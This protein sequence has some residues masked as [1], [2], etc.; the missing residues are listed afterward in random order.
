[1]TNEQGYE[2]F[3]APVKVGDI[4]YQVQI[5]DI[6]CCFC[7]YAKN[8]DNSICDNKE[9]K[10]MYRITEYEVTDLYK[11]LSFD[12][13]KLSLRY[14][15]FKTKEEALADIKRIKSQKTDNWYDIALSSCCCFV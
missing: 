10:Q 5:K 7:E 1:M 14:N 6:P 12:G 3:I 4:L 15:L 9:C 8:A 13:E 2:V 11:I